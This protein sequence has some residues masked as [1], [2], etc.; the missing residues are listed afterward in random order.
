MSRY[1][2]N[3]RVVGGKAAVPH[4][5]PSAVFLTISYK[6]LVY[7][8]GDEVLISTSYMC[9]GSLIDR[10][11]VLTAAHCIIENFNYHYNNR[12][13]V[14]N[15]TANEFYPTK[16][17]MF[18][19]FIGA[20]HYIERDADIKPAKVVSVEKAFRVCTILLDI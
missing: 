19:V 18:K 9:G 10:R 5:W 12:T 11:T 8:G 3:L 6:T 15:V 4:S 1:D 2:N 7:L 13:Y 20:D 14:I 17:S 16:G